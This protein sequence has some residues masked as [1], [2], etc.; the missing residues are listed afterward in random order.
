MFVP[1]P[2]DVAVFVSPPGSTRAQSLRRLS[3]QFEFTLTEA[4]DRPPELRNATLPFDVVGNVLRVTRPLDHEERSVWSLRVDVT[5]ASSLE[6]RDV[7]FSRQLD[8]RCVD[9][10]HCKFVWRY[11]RI[12]RRK[13][14]VSW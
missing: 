2:Q 10:S 7:Q 12:G 6:G 5:G 9:V 1:L 8:V 11:E 13:S 14:I 3:E 4:A